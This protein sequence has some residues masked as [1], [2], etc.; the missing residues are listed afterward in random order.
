MGFGPSAGWAQALTDLVAQDADLPEEQRLHPDRVTPST[1]PIWGSIIDDIWALDHLEEEGHTSIGPQWLD[2]AESAWVQ[3]G[4]APN[5][6]KS[7]NAVLGDE[8]QGYFVHPHGHW[9]GL[10]LEKRRLFIS[11]F[12]SCPFATVGSIQGPGEVDRE[13]WFHAFCTAVS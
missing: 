5:A 1:L 6:K 13:A 7:V 11:S 12:S 3:R 2:R 4:V 10:S 8:I 9:V